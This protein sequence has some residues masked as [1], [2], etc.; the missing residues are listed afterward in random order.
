MFTIYMTAAILVYNCT[1]YYGQSIGP[2]SG[3]LSRMW[4][5]AFAVV[6]VC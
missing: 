6:V 1:L 3:G 5:S 2:A 4:E